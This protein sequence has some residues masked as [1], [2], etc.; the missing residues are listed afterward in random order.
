[1]FDYNKLIGERLFYQTQ[2]DNYRMETK[3]EKRK[4]WIRS[5]HKLLTENRLE[6][7]LLVVQSNFL[8]LNK[9]LVAQA[10][11]FSTPRLIKY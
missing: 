2:N 7:Q 6:L 4:R 3:K 1:M 9:R 5:T 11:L 8:I 10:A